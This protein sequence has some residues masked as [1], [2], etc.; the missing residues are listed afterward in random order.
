[1]LYNCSVVMT[2]FSSLLAFLGMPLNLW[3]YSKV[4]NPTSDK[5]L[6]VPYTVIALSLVFISV[7]VIV[8]M[9]VRHFREKLAEKI[10]RVGIVW[11][12][13]SLFILFQ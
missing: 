12:L 2:T 13:C 4:L 10:T 9:T 11:I 8:G 6:M 7:P 3:L 5:A 1:M